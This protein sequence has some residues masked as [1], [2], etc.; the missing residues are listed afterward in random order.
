[1]ALKFTEKLKNIEIPKVSVQSL[2]NRGKSDETA[3]NTELNDAKREIAEKLA[4]K[5]EEL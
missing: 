2:L 4:T 3:D 1:M 5:T